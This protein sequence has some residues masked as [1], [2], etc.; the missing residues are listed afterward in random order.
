MSEIGDALKKIQ[1]QLSFIQKSMQGFEKRLASLERAVEQKLQVDGEN[2]LIYSRVLTRTLETIREYEKENG[3]GVVAKTLARIRDL[4][5]PTVYDHLSKLE[6][7]ELIF[8]QRG[9]ELGLKPYNGKFYSVTQREERLE[10]LPVLMALPDIVIPVAQA[11]LKAGNEGLS[12]TALM[13]IVT[14]LNEQN[15]KPWGSI[16]KKHIEKELDDSLQTLLRRV[17]IEHRKSVDHDYYLSR[18]R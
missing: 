10:D 14:R 9:T 6:E 13:D 18:S 7:A 3:H 1:K 8:W 16:S 2:P 12:K 17:L 15:E 4:E 5:Q 11:I